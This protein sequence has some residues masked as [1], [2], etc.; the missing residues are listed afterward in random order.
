[1][2]SSGSNLITVLRDRW[3]R[4]SS[5]TFATMALLV[6]AAMRLFSLMTGTRL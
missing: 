4:F 6:L 2:L 3:P 5:L 1:M